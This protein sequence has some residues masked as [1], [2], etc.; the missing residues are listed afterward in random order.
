MAI[1]QG[2]RAYACKLCEKAYATNKYLL[3][4]I[5]EIHFK[6]K[7]QC[8]LCSSSFARTVTYRNHVQARH[9]DIGEERMAHMMLRIKSLKPDYEKMEYYYAT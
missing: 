3:D 7:V 4:H 6:S 2:L 1:H 8:E 5:K 9:K